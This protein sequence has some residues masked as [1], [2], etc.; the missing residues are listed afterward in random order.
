MISAGFRVQGLVQGVG[1]RW[2]TRTH[3][4]ALALAGTVRNL[5][6]GS[7]EVRVSGTAEAVAELR[8]LLKAGPSGA[9]V[10]AVEAFDSPSIEGSSFEI[11]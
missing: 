3:A 2:W 5:A 9:V 7:V 8:R 6:D 4:R 11:S 1:F 10:R